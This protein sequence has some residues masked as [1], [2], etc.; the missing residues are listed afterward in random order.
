MPIFYCH[1][2][3]D[4]YFSTD[5]AEI[6]ANT[7]AAAAEIF[8]GQVF[9]DGADEL[10]PVEIIIAESRDGKNALRF[11]VKREHIIRDDASEV[12]PVVIPPADEED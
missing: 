4:S 3:A 12:G 10:S 5:C 8:G 2:E 9:D 7:A 6:E 11:E 1:T